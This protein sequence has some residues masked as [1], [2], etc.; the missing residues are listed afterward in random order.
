MRPWTRSRRRVRRGGIGDEQL[1]YFGTSYGTFLGATYA[2]LFPDKVRAMVLDAAVNP[3]AY[4]NTGAARE[5]LLN[6]GVRLGS[7]PADGRCMGGRMI[8]PRRPGGASAVPRP[9]APG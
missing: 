2:N 1:T 8:S 6:T 7:D 9:P 4:L 5:L 3:Q